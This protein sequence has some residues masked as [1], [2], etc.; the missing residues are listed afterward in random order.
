MDELQHII[1]QTSTGLT[2]III[3]ENKNWQL[4]D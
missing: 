1:S 2:E 3:S 4:L